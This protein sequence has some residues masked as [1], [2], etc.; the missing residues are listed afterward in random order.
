MGYYSLIL[1]LIIESKLYTFYKLFRP[2]ETF[3]VPTRKFLAREVFCTDVRDEIRFDS[4]LGKCFVMTVKDY[5]R[6]RPVGFDDKD[7]WVCENR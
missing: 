4:I 1:S 3:H 5:F 2:I 6:M 7:V